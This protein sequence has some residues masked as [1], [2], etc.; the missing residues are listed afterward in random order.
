MSSSVLC[1]PHLPPEVEALLSP[2]PFAPLLAHLLSLVPFLGLGVTDW[3]V[4][5]GPLQLALTPLPFTE[6]AENLAL[7]FF[8]KRQETQWCVFNSRASVVPGKGCQGRPRGVYLG[9][10]VTP[11]SFAV[12]DG[13]TPSVPRPIHNI[14]PLAFH[15]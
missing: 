5:S 12:Y 8:W 7:D 2:L 11:S 13:S 4:E 15:D 3:E 9:L 10:G 14:F 6:L 1:C